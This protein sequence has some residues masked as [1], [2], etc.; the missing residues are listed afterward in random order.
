MRSVLRRVL[1]RLLWLGVFLVL[2]VALVFSAIHADGGQGSLASL[3]PPPATPTTTPIFFGMYPTPASRPPSD[4]ANTIS[5]G[6][7]VWP[8][9]SQYRSVATPTPPTPSSQ[10]NRR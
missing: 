10:R 2:C 1:W 5:T 9:S 8:P 3:F 6:D 7:V 4:P